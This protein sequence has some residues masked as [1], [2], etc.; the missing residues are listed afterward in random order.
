MIFISPTGNNEV[1][2]VKPAGYFTEEEWKKL[3]PDM[4]YSVVGTNSCRAVSYPYDGIFENEV[5]MAGL[6]PDDISVSTVAGEWIESI[7]L[8]NEKRVRAKNS[9]LEELNTRF[10]QVCVNAHCMSSVGFEINADEAANRN[11]SSLIIALEATGQETVR[12]CAWDNS[13]HDVTLAQL[14]AMQLEIIVHAQAIYQQKWALRNRINSA[15]T[16]EALDAI[17]ITFAATGEAE[18]EDDEQTV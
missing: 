7:E 3:H 16:I 11:I 1:W 5:E 15:E 18:G 13:F 8:L 9:R 14:K 6:P 10:D 12:F 17:E 2:D 4:I